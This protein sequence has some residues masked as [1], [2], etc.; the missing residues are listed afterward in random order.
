MT[1]KKTDE[2]AP[3][4][5]ENVDDRNEKWATTIGKPP[6]PVQTVLDQTPLAEPTYLSGKPILDLKV[7]STGAEVLKLQKA[8]NKRLAAR[9]QGFWIPEDGVYGAK[10]QSAVENAQAEDGL[11]VIGEVTAAMFK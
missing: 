2:A 7:G 4:K 3:V 1:S 10:T 9:G 6:L 8:L 11:P 5:K